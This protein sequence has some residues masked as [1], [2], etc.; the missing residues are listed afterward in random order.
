MKRPVVRIG[1]VFVGAL[2]NLVLN[3]QKQEALELEVVT[4]AV[5]YVYNGL[6]SLEMQLDFGL[7]GKVCIGHVDHKAS[8]KE[9]SIG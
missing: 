4:Q 9:D 5:G 6:V 7:E 3:V 8:W 1:V 2:P